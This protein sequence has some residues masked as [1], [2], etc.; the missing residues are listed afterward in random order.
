VRRFD[1]ARTQL[2]LLQILIAINLHSSSLKE[3]YL[4]EWDFSKEDVV[5]VVNSYLSDLCWY[6]VNLL[7][8]RVNRQTF[9]AFAWKLKTHC[10]ANHCVQEQRSALEDICTLSLYQRL[11]QNCPPEFRAEWLAKVQNMEGADGVT[12]RKRMKCHVT[13]WTSEAGQDAHDVFE[14]CLPIL[15]LVTTGIRAAT[16]QSATR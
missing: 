13:Q 12:L 3:L 10:R 16:K 9:E 7:T 11:D 15:R 5:N 2:D 4:M 14:Y 6:S 8:L 1:H